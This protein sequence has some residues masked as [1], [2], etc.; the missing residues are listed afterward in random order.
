MICDRC[1]NNMQENTTVC[2]ICGMLTA[3]ARAKLEPST[4]Y[5]S[6]P[7]EAF[8]EPSVYERG[9]TIQAVPP[10]PPR[11]EYAPPRTQ[12]PYS[13]AP[14]RYH[15]TT[16]PPPG[17]I[18]MTVVNIGGNDGAL[19]AEILFSLFGIFGVGWLIG[20]ETTIGVVLL[21]ASFT[22]YWPIMFG[23][24]IITFGLGLILLGPIA[25][26]TIIINAVLLSNR[27]RRKATRYYY[28]QQQQPPHMHVPPRP[29]E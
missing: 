28:T 25:I 2:P 1:G 8:G 22:L 24:T 18:H 3:K 7:P 15:Y 13:Y 14:P 12:Q 19:I 20:G 10:P 17:P 4:S 26:G 27:L 23:G 11:S 9:Y 21:I 6:Y 29:Q 5:G 16:Q